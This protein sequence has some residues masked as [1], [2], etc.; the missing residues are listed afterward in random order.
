[1][2]GLGRA[3]RGRTG[4]DLLNEAKLAV[5]KGAENNGCGRS[6]NRNVNFVT[7]L[8]GIMRSISSHW[9]RDFDEQEPELESEI[10]TSTK[11]GE[12]S[13]PLDNAVCRAPSQER[14]LAA[15]QQFNLIAAQCKGNRDASYV[16]E[17]LSLGLTASPIVQEYKLSKSK[18][19]QAM[20]RIRL[21]VWSRDGS[22]LY[23]RSSGPKSAMVM[24]TRIGKG[25]EFTFSPP[26]AL[27]RFGC[28]E[29]GAHDYGVMSNGQ[30]VLH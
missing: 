5:L 27:F 10:L 25:E 3:S 21:H 7:Y 22:E 13:S 11:E 19:Q 18:Y 9:K 8:S 26:Q 4:D 17:G 15:R 20:K 14:E 30:K 2:Q 12:G 1:M 24:S 29:A 28:V 6:W 23:F 16:L